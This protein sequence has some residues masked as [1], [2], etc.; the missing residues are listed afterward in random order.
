[1]CIKELGGYGLRT[2]TTVHQFG[3]AVHDYW[4][5]SLRGDTGFELRW[6]KRRD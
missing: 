5:S 2:A 1:M 3:D 6:C 4:S